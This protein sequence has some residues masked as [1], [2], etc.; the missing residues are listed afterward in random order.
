MSVEKTKK[1]RLCCLVK[2]V[3]N[4]SKCKTSLCKV[5]SKVIF[6]LHPDDDSLVTGKYGGRVIQTRVCLKDWK[7]Y[8][9]RKV[10]K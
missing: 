4:C 7:C 3:G 6:S 5:H 1:D 9:R 2:K 10:S 8:I